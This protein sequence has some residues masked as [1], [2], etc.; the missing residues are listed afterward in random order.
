MLAS[1]S[2]KW[3][4]F[5]AWSSRRPVWCTW[6]VTYRCNFRCGFCH[7]WRD[8]MGALPEQSL[9][10]FAAGSKKL[11]QMGSLLVSLAGGEPLL[12]PDL[13][14]IVREVARYHFPFVTTSGWHVTAELAEQLF[15]A[16]LWGASVSI[17][18]ADPRQHDKARGTRGAFER[19][20]AALAHFSRARKYPWQR[21]NLMAV[22]LH[23]NQDQLDDLVRLA[24]EHDAFFMIQP[25]GVRKTGSTRFVA[26]AEGVSRRLLELKDRH[27]NILSN[28]VFLSRFDQALNG[29]VPGCRAGTAF[30]NIDSCGDIAICV[31]ERADPVANL[32]RDPTADIVRALNARARA[33]NCTDCWY[34][35]RGEVEMLYS[36][37]SL[38][39][40]LPTLFLDRGRPSQL[41]ARGN[42]RTRRASSPCNRP[43]VTS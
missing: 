26:P 32:Y 31:E 16:G 34:N 6:Q 1:T 24:A 39:Q 2:K 9:E 19:A 29:G 3:R 4:L 15:T 10:D 8:P 43:T 11:A 41:E 14:Q 37:V 35:C 7:Y 12:R 33:T 30:F 36:P 17:D 28:R 18:Y 40:S 27:A 13:V 38:I 25:Y 42:G 23:D 21:V 22:L 5:R 20:E